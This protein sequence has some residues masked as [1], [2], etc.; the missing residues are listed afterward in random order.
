MKIGVKKDK[1]TRLCWQGP[2]VRPK[3]YLTLEYERGHHHPRYIP[4]I[5]GNGGDLLLRSTLT[6]QK[7]ISDFVPCLCC[8]DF[9]ELVPLYGAPT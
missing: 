5:P 9:D 3:E 7:Q 1:N 6:T 2:Q 8:E 4:E